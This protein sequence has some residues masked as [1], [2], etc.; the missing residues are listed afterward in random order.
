MIGDWHL[1]DRCF[2]AQ[3]QEVIIQLYLLNFQPH[4]K[5]N[6]ICKPYEAAGT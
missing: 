3:K 1:D 6:T 2:Y 5:R 4:K